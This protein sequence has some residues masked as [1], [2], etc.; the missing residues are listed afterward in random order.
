[1]CVHAHAQTTITKNGIIQ[2][3]KFMFS[4]YDE[5]LTSIHTNIYIVNTISSGGREYYSMDTSNEVL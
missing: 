1:M 4:T 2:F 3:L 5:S